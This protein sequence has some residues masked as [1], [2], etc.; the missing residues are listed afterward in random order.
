MVWS[1][2]Y[3]PDGRRLAIGQ[4]GGI[5]G[6]GSVLRV[7]DVAGKREVISMARPSAYRCVAFSPDG[8][9]LAA[10]TFDC[11]VEIYKTEGDVA[12]LEG[13]WRDLGEPI[14]A[15]AFLPNGLLVAGDWAGRLLFFNTPEP[16]RRQLDPGRIFTIAVS[17]D[18]STLAVAGQAGDI[19]VYDVP[20]GRKYSTSKGHESAVESLAYSPD[21]KLLASAGWDHTVRLWDRSGRAVAVLKGHDRQVLCVRF[22]PDGKVL[23]SSEG[24]TDVR[25]FEN[26]PCDD[27]ALGRRHAR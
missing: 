20:S 3:S 25:H 15:L 16:A 2:A 24:Q 17:P 23:A 21:G 7:W 4:Q 10:G 9:R 26:M 19:N 13:F 5:D 11:V 14:N 8:K 6:L 18:G 12:M 22:S 1:L 27:Q